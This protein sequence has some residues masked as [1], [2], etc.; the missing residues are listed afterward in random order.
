MDFQTAVALSLFSF[1]FFL[2]LNF[3][4]RRISVPISLAVLEDSAR[5]N[6]KVWEWYNIAVSFAHSCLSGCIAVFW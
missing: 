5:K 1:M 3:T 6:Y 2:M 4:F